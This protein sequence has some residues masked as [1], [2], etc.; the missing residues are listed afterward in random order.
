MEFYKID[1]AWGDTL[2]TTSKQ[3]Q[4]SYTIN[5]IN[6]MIVDLSRY[7][8]LIAIMAILIVVIVVM[9]RLCCRS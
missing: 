6:N 7:K 1:D 9:R 2:E 5:K 8:T 3:D 4:G